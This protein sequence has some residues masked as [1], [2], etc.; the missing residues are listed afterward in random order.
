MKKAYIITYDQDEKDDYDELVEELKKS[1]SWWKYLD[2]TWIIV[3]NESSDD[4]W[5]RIKDKINKEKVFLIMEV[6]GKNRQG[7]LR[8]SQW[9]W[10]KENLEK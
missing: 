7:W 9:D 5:K 3:T 4:V 8:K 10:I 2:R 6:N 1:D